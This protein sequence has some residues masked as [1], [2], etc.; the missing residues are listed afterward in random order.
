M[1]CALYSSWKYFKTFLFY[2]NVSTNK[3][4][5][6]LTF[7]KPQTPCT[8][9]TDAAATDVGGDGVGSSE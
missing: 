8:V 6:F 1:Q 4:L 2:S 5:H 7:D 9:P 3:Y